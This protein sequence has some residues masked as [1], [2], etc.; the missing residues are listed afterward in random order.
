MKTMENNIVAYLIDYGSLLG[1]QAYEYE[2]GGFSARSDRLK[3][4]VVSV[5]D[6]ITDYQASC[7]ENN[8]IP[9]TMNLIRYS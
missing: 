3:Q 1:Y 4:K 6:T 5:Q 2:L 7:A 9:Y 8:V